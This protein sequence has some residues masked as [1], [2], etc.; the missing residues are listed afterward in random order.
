MVRVPPRWEVRG[1]FSTP[2]PISGHRR[3][4]WN[5]PPTASCR[6]RP[7]LLTGRFPS[8]EAKKVGSAKKR[9]SWD[10]GE[11]V[12]PKV[13][14][15]S[16]KKIAYSCAILREGAS[17]SI[18]QGA[19]DG[20][21]SRDFRC[22]SHC[23]LWEVS[24]LRR[25][26]HLTSRR[27]SRSRRRLTQSGGTISRSSDRIDGRKSIPRGLPPNSIWATDAAS[28]LTRPTRSQRRNGWSPG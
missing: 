13:L 7:R 15:R 18:R 3:I 9:S 22:P 27:W 26:L 17:R 1:R 4:C 24:H 25:T 19:A 28:S 20:G 2:L 12:T 5:L 14:C 10:L 6:S 11:V 21:I 8:S 16:R 23:G